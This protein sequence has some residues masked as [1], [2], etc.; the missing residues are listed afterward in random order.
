MTRANV[1]QEVRRELSMVAAAASLG[2]T[3]R[4]VRRWSTRYEAEG[5][6]DIIHDGPNKAV[7]ATS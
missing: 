7:R 4:T 3:E 2:V 1:L 6:A 5:L